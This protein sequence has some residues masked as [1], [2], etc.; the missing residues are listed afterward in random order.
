MVEANAC[1]VHVHS[2]SEIAIKDDSKLG[3]YLDDERFTK[4]SR[5]LT[6]TQQTIQ[7]GSYE[8]KFRYCLTCVP[9]KCHSLRI[10]E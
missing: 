4:E 6:K 5:V 8:Q 7:L 1:K 2:R 9:H 10:L 3:T